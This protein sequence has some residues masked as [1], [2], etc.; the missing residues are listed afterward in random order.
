M[1]YNELGIFLAE[2]GFPFLFRFVNGFVGKK[3]IINSS[4]LKERSYNKVAVLNRKQN[5]LFLCLP[6]I[7]IRA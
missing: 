2:E 5:E 3:V 6:K 7:Y 4:N 1:S